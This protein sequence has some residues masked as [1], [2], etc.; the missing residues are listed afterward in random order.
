MNG[1]LALLVRLLLV[2]LFVAFVFFRVPVP[3]T[4]WEMLQCEPVE[5]VE[6]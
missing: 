6:S 5:S 2:V 4:L 3:D 1:R